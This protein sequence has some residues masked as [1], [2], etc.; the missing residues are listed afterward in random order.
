MVEKQQNFGVIVEQGGEGGGGA[1]EA[2]ADADGFGEQGLGGLGMAGEGFHGGEVVE[3]IEGVGAF[4]GADDLPGGA[5]LLEGGFGVGQVAHR[6]EGDAE[7]VLED[8]D[9][10]VGGSGDGDAFGEGDPEQGGGAG[11]ILVDVADELGFGETAIDEIGAPAFG[12]G[13]PELLGFLEVCAGG[14][15]VA[16]ADEDF[17]EVDFGFGDDLR[18][19]AGGE[20]GNWG[21][22]GGGAGVV[23]GMEV[24]FAEGLHDGAIAG[25]VAMELAGEAGGGAGE[26]VLTAAVGTSG[27]G[28]FAEEEEEGLADGFG[29]VGFD[30]GGV[31]GGGG[32]AGL[33]EG[34]ASA[35][36]ETGGNCRRS[37][38]GPAGAPEEAAEAVAAFTEAG[39]D[40]GSGGG[41]LE[42][43]S[44][45]LEGGVATGR[46]LA[47][48][49]GEDGV[50]VFEES[51][52]GVDWVLAEGGGRLI[53]D[54]ADAE[55]GGET[56]QGDGRDAGGEFVEQSGE[57]VDI[58]RR[59]GGGAGEEFGGGVGGGDGEGPFSLVVGAHA[60]GDAKV[61][62]FGAAL[63]V[64]ENV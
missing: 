5:G 42:I 31:A 45:G 19:E 23:V 38:E 49:F 57:A 11:G 41:G 39:G 36:Q 53:E 10:A 64:D 44:E 1:E 25:G 35:K 47:E 60:F 48:G 62:D 30:D 12:V 16:H 63:G 55:G 50:E 28:G 51:G 2:P 33:P 14:L 54:A 58:G 13:A 40:A 26:N 56:G 15:G 27:L 8:A 4:V 46:F 18:A 32:D 20:G 34:E 21:E 22:Q 17:G 61:D 43:G 37:S 3:G 24:E 9:V 52:G 6:L 59:T 29:A 7:V